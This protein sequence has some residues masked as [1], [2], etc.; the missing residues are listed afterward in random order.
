MGAFYI[1]NR[2][3]SVAIWK[4]HNVS[5]GHIFWWAQ[6]TLQISTKVLL[7]RSHKINLQHINSSGC[8]LHSK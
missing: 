1:A 2:Y 5:S 3:H 8:R 4:S 7:Y 6:T